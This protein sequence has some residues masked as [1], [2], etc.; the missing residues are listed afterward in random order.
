MTKSRNPAV[1]TELTVADVMFEA[2]TVVERPAHLAAAAYLMQNLHTPALI[3]ID[4]DSRKPVA[5]ITGRDIVRAVAHGINA[6]DETVA[7]WETPDPLSVR[8]QTTVTEAVDLMLDS[9]YPQL[10]VVDDAHTLVGMIDLYHYA[11][12]VRDAQRHRNR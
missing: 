4:N 1:E 10:P 5:L 8:P 3:V 11:R 7:A 12:A 9:G 2:V 6:A